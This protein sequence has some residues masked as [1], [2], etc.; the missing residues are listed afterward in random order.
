[1]LADLLSFSGAEKEACLRFPD[2]HQKFSHDRHSERTDELPEFVQQILGVLAR[3]GDGMCPH[4]KCPLD[5]LVSGFDF[6]HAGSREA[7]C[8]LVSGF[9]G[10]EASVW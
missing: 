1:M 3:F 8:G 7:F 6:K 4:K 9:L 5:H 2:L 10:A